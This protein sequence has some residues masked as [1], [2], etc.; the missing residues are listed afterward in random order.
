MEDEDFKMTSLSPLS[1]SITLTVS[2]SV[3]A[4]SAD[5]LLDVG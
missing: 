1:A 5:D 3:E 4:T 2:S